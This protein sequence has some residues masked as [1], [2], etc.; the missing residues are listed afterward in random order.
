[1]VTSVVGVD[2]VVVVVVSISVVS[3]DDVVVTGSD[4]EVVVSASVVSEVVMLVL[5]SLSLSP[6]W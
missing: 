5:V 6:V 4:V 2:D 3:I 1:M